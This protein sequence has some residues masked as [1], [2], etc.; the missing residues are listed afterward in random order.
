MRIDH[1]IL[2]LLQVGDLE[3]FKSVPLAMEKATLP[4]EEVRRPWREL[5][6]MRETDGECACVVCVG[7]WKRFLALSPVCSLWSR[8]MKRRATKQALMLCMITF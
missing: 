5:W 8:I 2:L 4:P 6:A 1:A 3:K 7:S